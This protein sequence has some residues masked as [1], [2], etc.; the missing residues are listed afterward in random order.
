M[1]RASTA[2]IHSIS[3][4]PNLD[5]ANFGEGSE[6]FASQWNGNM[7]AHTKD[8]GGGSQLSPE[9]AIL[10]AASHLRAGSGD[11]SMDSS[12]DASMT[13][14]MSYTHD[15]S[16]ARRS[17]QPAMP[18]ND[19]SAFTDPDSQMLDV[20]DDEV[21]SVAAAAPGHRSGASRTSANNEREM[22][23]LFQASKHRSLQDVARELHGNERGPNSERQR[24]VFAMLW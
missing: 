19:M 20:R 12:M 17:I 21:D 14:H 4:Q 13:H 11:F 24:Q 5:Q 8:L 22:Q 10:Q 3:T 18:V 15:N 6:V 23:L 16:F 7:Q 2:S 9:D 1:S